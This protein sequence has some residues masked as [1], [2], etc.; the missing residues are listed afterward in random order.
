[1]QRTPFDRIRLI[2]DEFTI[3]K[4]SCQG[5]SVSVELIQAFNYHHGLSR[6]RN[7]TQVALPV[8]PQAIIPWDIDYRYDSPNLLRLRV[9]DHTIHRS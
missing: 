5:W 2:P 3:E 7:A 6:H 8:F 9:L 1:M 4:K